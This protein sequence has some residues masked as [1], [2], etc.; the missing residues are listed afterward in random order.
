[1]SALRIPDLLVRENLLTSRQMEEHVAGAQKKNVRLLEHLLASN[2]VDEQTLLQFLARHARLT[3]MDLS[4]IDLGPDIVQLLPGALCHKHRIL[5]VGRRGDTLVIAV[6]DPTNVHALDEIRF[7]TK[8]R[9]EQV[10]ALPSV[11]RSLIDRYYANDSSLSKALASMGDLEGASE[12]DSN[13]NSAGQDGFSQDDAP[14]IQFVSG[15]LV[16][17]IRK[18]SSDIHIEPYE[19]DFRVRLRIDGDLV[20]AMRPPKNI[21]NALIARI[22][23]MAKMRID[24]KRL[25]QDGRVRLRLPDGKIVDFRVNTLPTVHGEK[26]V[27]RILDRSNAAVSLEKLG[28]EKDELERFVTAIKKPWGMCLVTG[29]TG[30]GKTTTLYAALNLLNQ[31]DVNISTIEDPVE[32]NFTGINQVQVRDDIGLSFGEALRSLLRQDPDIVLLGEIRDKD[33]AEIAFKAALTGHMVL[34]TLHTNDA[35]SSIMRLKDM[36]VDAFLI[37]SAVQMV[38]A[39]RL[40]R[41][42]CSDC[43][44]V[45]TRHSR[46][47][48]QKMGFPAHILD[49]FKPVRGKGCP[50]C[51]NTG[52][53][54]RVA[55]H[56]VMVVTE[57]LREKIGAGATTEELRK[58]AVAEGMRTLKVNTLRKIVSG[59]CSVDEIQFVTTDD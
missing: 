43:K 9:V 46:E 53:R 24:E 10:L 3:I 57:R 39:Q 38:L 35:P 4:D 5:P 11:L 32:Y 19:S 26:V 45:D 21:Q 7:Q 8:L 54:G 20:D 49:K 28:F 30:S 58:A 59:V 48:L 13:Q 36:G 47:E 40:V 15:I 34:S 52:Y 33:T 14:I 31:V 6:S 55:V 12:V 23:V 16:D 50:S 41:R 2:A 51:R 18:K 42:V 27:L 22:K 56:E 17:A 29:P 25:P 37:N 44:E 1:V